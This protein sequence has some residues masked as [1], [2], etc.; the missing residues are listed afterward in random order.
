MEA[1]ALAGLGVTA[2]DEKDVQAQVL[3]DAEGGDGQGAV[4]VASGVDDAAAADPA[5]LRRRLAGIQKE[6]NALK[7]VLKEAS[8]E[9]SQQVQRALT[10]QRLLELR[11]SRK[12]VRAALAAGGTSA[13]KE[14]EGLDAAFEDAITGL[15]ETERDRLIRVGAITPFDNLDGFQRQ[16]HPSVRAA[17]EKAEAIVAGRAR[18]KLLEGAAVPK[19]P[20]P[21]QPF[22]PTLL[23]STGK[24]PPRKRIAPLPPRPKHKRR[25]DADDDPDEAYS[26]D[27]D[28][29]AEDDDKD[30]WAYERRQRRQQAKDGEDHEACE[31][32]ELEGGLRIPS[33][34][35]LLDYQRVGVK[36]LWELHCMRVGGILGDEQGLGKTVQVSSFLGA[37]HASG[38]YSPS[39]VVC[40]ATLLRQWLRELRSWHPAFRV[41]VLHGPASEGERDKLVQTVAT[42]RSG[43]LLTSYE[44]ARVQRDRLLTVRWGYAVLDEGHKIRNPDAE[45]TLVLKQL[46]TVHRLIMTGSP[47]QNRLTELWSLV[48]FVFP[49][50]LG[51]LPVFEAQFAVPIAIG[52]YASATALQVSTAH[53]CAV[54]LRDLIAPYLLRRL[55]AHVGAN[56]LPAKSEHVLLCALTPE[57]RQTYRAFLASPDFEAVL[58]GK[59]DALAAI[60]VLRKIC[61]HPDLLERTTSSNHPDYGNPSRAAKLRA[62]A[63]LLPAWQAEGHRALVF[64]QTVMMLDILE[65]HVE[66]AGLQYRRMDGTTPVQQ[67]MRLIDEFNQDESIFVFLLTTRVGGLGTNLTGA[68]RVVIYDP[69]WNPSTDVQ[70]RERAWR[71][72]QKRA[73]TVYRLVTAGTIEEKIYHRQI[74]KHFLS[75][76]ILR[77]PRQKRLFKHKDLRDLFTLADETGANESSDTAKLFEVDAT[78]T[79]TG[80]EKA[81]DDNDAGDAKDG[82]SHILKELFDGK[83]GVQSAINHDAILKA[84]GNERVVIDYEASRVAHRAAESLRQSRAAR[85]QQG[86]S[87]LTWTGHHGSAG[88]PLARPRGRFGNTSNMRL[89]SASSLR[90]AT[91]AGGGVASASTSPFDPTSAKAPGVTSSNALLA[92]IRERQAQNSAPAASDTPPEVDD[93]QELLGRICIFL[94]QHGGQASS[95]QVA[96]AFQKD[97][98]AQQ[99]MALFRQL[100]R[101]AAT[102]QRNSDRGESAWVLKSEFHD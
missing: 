3:A 12:E 86:V 29:S 51:T 94:R 33:W 24:A 84:S 67:R 102:L 35:R 36:W 55:K 88:A 69:D 45:T 38:F 52:G 60:S 92:K 23:R 4:A 37:L 41:V 22:H 6:V 57:Q 10:E 7:E 31:E 64:T 34:G 79:T 93:A 28:R 73:V 97:A 65:M 96:D 68:N 82:D 40:P 26:G 77:D 20:L 21:A 14:D 62:L 32:V 8:H 50:K 72:G 81:D 15:I 63:A 9:A 101:Q 11:R 16:V 74:Y 100:L 95:S 53:K 2:V 61:N 47:I 48:D 30:D 43:I 56:V 18:T 66:K 76:R 58:D 19:Q 5:A 89:L 80:Q 90:P 54:V 1:D 46:Q 59:R 87:A 25:R 42:D 91:P 71:I 70:A 13:L 27:S 39:L 75:D 83:T 98:T 78:E 44:A 99:D 85:L 49:G 17:A